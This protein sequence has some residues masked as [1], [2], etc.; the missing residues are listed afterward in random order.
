MP[1]SMPDACSSPMC[2]HTCIPAP[3]T[4][5]PTLAYTRLT[6]PPAHPPA[7]PP[8]H[9]THAPTHPPTH[10]PTCHEQRPH[11]DGLER[12]QPLAGIVHV[13][14][15][16]AHRQNGL[17][18]RQYRGEPAVQCKASTGQWRRGHCQRPLPPLRSRASQPALLCSDGHSPT[19]PLVQ[20]RA[21]EQKRAPA[22]NCGGRW[23]ATQHRRQRHSG[24]VDLF[25]HAEMWRRELRKLAGKHI[26][27]LLWH[28]RPRSAHLLPLQPPQRIA[29]QAC[30][31]RAAAPL[32]P[33]PT[34]R[35]G[36]ARAG[37]G[38]RQAGGR[39]MEVRDECAGSCSRWLAAAAARETNAAT[40]VRC[41]LQEGALAGSPRDAPVEHKL[42]LLFPIAGATGAAAAA[43]AAAGG[44][45]IRRIDVECE[46]GAGGIV[47]A[48]QLCRQAVQKA[49]QEALEKQR[50]RSMV[51][52]RRY[53]GGSKSHAALPHAQPQPAHHRHTHLTAHPHA[54]TRRPAR[55]PAPT[56]PP[57]SQP[58]RT[59]T[60]P[61]A[62]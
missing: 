6:R 53:M 12:L 57:A 17:H 22:P 10:P 58:A 16:D 26:C 24:A 29:Q 33:W 56:R 2:R 48:V 47:W 13:L 5:F 61:P 28:C 3:P 14:C 45:L 55:Q 11:H 25:Q 9:P 50:V 23:P 31:S 37:Q 40:R 38:G 34:C 4:R 19:S 51:R 46:A 44:V 62:S 54:H 35:Q 49:V 59:H 1:A 36:R 15:H 42:R 43:I 20:V 8:T 30:H 7:H 60:H 39:C 18:C 21:M 52:G 32:D 41:V 27:C